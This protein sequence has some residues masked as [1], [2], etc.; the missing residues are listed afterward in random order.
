MNRFKTTGLI[1][2]GLG[3]LGSCFY[4]LVHSAPV[5]QRTAP[6]TA[7]ENKAAGDEMQTPP[8]RPSQT[9]G[10]APAGE[11]D[12]VLRPTATRQHMVSQLRDTY[13][14][15]IDSPRIQVET[16]QKLIAWL[17]QAYPDLWQEHVAEYLRAAFPENADALYDRYLSLEEYKLGLKEDHQAIMTMPP[18]DRRDHLWARR[19]MLFGEDALEIWDKEYKQLQVSEALDQIDGLEGASFEE[20]ATFYDLSLTQIYGEEATDYKQDHTQQAV[21]HFFSIESIQEDLRNM[22]PDQRMEK[23]SALRRA[24]GM[25]EPAVARWAELDAARD[26]RWRAGEAYMQ[27]RDQILEESG[28]GYQSSELDALRQEF[29]G[30][31]AETIRNEEQSGYFRFNRKRVYGQN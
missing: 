4:L 29:F 23:M 19:K 14:G 24:M 3:L 16:I 7:R 2:G 18:G 11:N 17:K 31:E 6:P 15:N 10:Q 20:K 13:A 9:T 22:P 27:R 21:D 28:G 1:L 5:D 8:A 30:T 25:D 12:E 26:Q